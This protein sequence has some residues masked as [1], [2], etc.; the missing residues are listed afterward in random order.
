MKLNKDKCEVIAIN[1][2]NQIKCRDGTPAKHANEATYLGGKLTVDTNPTTEIQN[3]IAACIPNMKTLKIMLEHKITS[4]HNKWKINV[5]NAVIL[6]KLIYGLETVQCTES[7]PTKTIEFP[8]ET[9]KKHFRHSTHTYR[10][11]MDK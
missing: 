8:N 9:D 2:D 5:F 4:C 1:K 3:I 10:Q 6:T 7:H 11:I